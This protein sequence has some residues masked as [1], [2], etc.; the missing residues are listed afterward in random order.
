MRTK[1][2]PSVRIPP[3]GTPRPGASERPVVFTYHDYRLFLKDWLAYRRASQS[4]FSLRTLARQ[5]GMAAGYLPM[6]LSGKRPL[7][8]QMLSRLSNFLGLSASEQSYLASL[9]EFGTAA[10]PGA[11]LGAL[12]RMRRFGNYQALN[13]RESE[14]IEYL[15]H[16]HYVAIREMAALPDFSPDPEAIQARLRVPVPLGEIRAALD[17]LFKN[18][19]IE[20]LPDGRVR[21]PEKALDCKGSVYRVALAK[22][23]R[24]IFDLAMKSIENVPG[25]ERNIQGHMFALKSGNYPKAVEIVED[26][27][28]RI[29]ELGETER[30]G[31]SVY[32]LEIALFPVTRRR[33]P[34]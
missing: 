32:H 28:R 12:E 4:G 30:E 5:A 26:A 22:F 16:W 1:R 25:T 2:R 21:P 17:F 9:T 27:I 34:Q 13:Q 15:T 19:F 24:E 6:I 3:A 23:H 7:T 11:R 29:R 33:D 14:L 10:S 18:G 20:A 31:D 8:P